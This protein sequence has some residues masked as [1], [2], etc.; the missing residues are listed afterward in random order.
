MA[1]AGPIGPRP[2]THGIGW[3]PKDIVTHH[4]TSTSSDAPASFDTLGLSTAMLQTIAQSGFSTPT[5]IQVMAIP[6]ALAGKDVIGCA[7]TGTGKTLAFLAP[8]IERLSPGLG[9]K[10]LILAPT[11]ELALQ[12]DDQA[13][14]FGRGRGVRTALLIGGVGY[15]DQRQH[16]KELRPIVIATPGRLI[17][18]LEEG[19]VKFDGLKVLVLD[20][21]DRMLDMG[22][23]PQLTRIL[24]QVPKVRQ[25]MLFSATMAGEVADFARAHLHS[26]VRVEV[27]KS[28]TTLTQIS[29]KAYLT[30]ATDK[31]A[32]LV[33]LL[34]RDEA[35]ALVFTRTKHRADKVARVLE[36][37]GFSAARIHG[38]RSQNQRVQALEGFREGKYRVLVATDIAARGLD[39]EGIGHVVNFDLPHVP[40]DYVH[41][42]GRTGRAAASGHAS[43]L[44]ST[45]ELGLLRDIERFI[46]Q[47]VPRGE[48]APAELPASMPQGGGHAHEAKR[49]GGGHGQRGGGHG[50]G[51]RGGRR[52]GGGGGGA[53]S[54]SPKPSGVVVFR[55]GPRG[56]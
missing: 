47:P 10:V 11:R 25:T 14:K 2:A 19:L 16:V 38:N 44:V 56:R 36:K 9:V 50:G 30:G 51:G 4:Q 13:Q 20:E 29:Q 27:H 52:G 41:R 53:K 55:G 42:I 17:D 22:F 3:L 40:E 46:R 37:V 31:G 49:H 34:Q 18:F 8:I 24:H 12:I 28:G 6:P 32:T 7:A 45:D 15:G 54:S 33:A 21:A 5:P 1:R 26:P 23:K 43:S 39:V 35:S 48:I